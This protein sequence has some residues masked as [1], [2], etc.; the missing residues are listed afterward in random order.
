MSTQPIVRFVGQIRGHGDCSISAL[1]MCLGMTYAQT[2]VAVSAVAPKVLE[3]GATYHQIQRAAKRLG[4]T[5]V[6]RRTRIDLDD[7]DTE[8]ILCVNFV[9][10]NEIHAVYLKRS[11]V[12]DGRTDSVWDADVY[13]RIHNCDVE[14][15]LVRTA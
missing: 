3:E 5:L 10:S 13:L 11:L 2:L 6:M 12:F 8:G 9:G 4:A 1:A 15:L 14:C 7:E